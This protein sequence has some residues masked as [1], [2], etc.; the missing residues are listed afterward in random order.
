[1]DSVLFLIEAGRNIGLGHL[2]RCRALMQELAHRGIALE[3]V[4][5]GDSSA[6]EGRNWSVAE[7]HF[8]DG[9][10]P[11]EAALEEAA[12]RAKQA[13]SHWVV[14][15]GYGFLDLGLRRTFAPAASR[16][17][18]LDDFVGR[19]IDADLLLNQNTAEQASGGR[20]M[21]PAYTLIEH[22]YLEA[23]RLRADRG[24]SDTDTPLRKLLVSFGGLDSEDS[25]GH[26][27]DCLETPEAAAGVLDI[28]VVVGPFYAHSEALLARRSRHRLTVHRNVPGLAPLMAATDA[29]VSGAGTTAWQACCVGVP[30]LAVQAVDNQAEVARTLHETGAALVADGA[31][32]PTLAAA[33]AKLGNPRVRR[34]LSGKAKALVDGGG[35]TRVADAMASFATPP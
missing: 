29:M 21:G 10:T 18:V 16:L 1:M 26:V 8:I 23:R 34:S 20:L 31:T 27:L 2:L 19:P 4:L 35:A 14:I 22:D 3:M 5:R 17:L 15:D 11:A 25:T 6:L 24:A 9:S 13:S 33:L 7:V 28:D 12:R 32:D 30:L